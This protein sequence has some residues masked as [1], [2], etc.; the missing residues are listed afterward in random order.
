MNMI[1][2]MGGFLSA[3]F[4]LHN[5]LES[6]VSSG[7]NSIVYLRQNAVWKYLH[8][9]SEG[10]TLTIKPD[11]QE[12]GLLYTIDGSIIIKKECP[13]LAILRLNTLILIRVQLADGTFRILGTNEYPLQATLRPITPSKASGFTGYELSFSGKQLIEP[14]LLTV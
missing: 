9:K 12:P 13:S 6:F 10:V 11:K 3:D 4:I 8:A 14:P 2:N 7:S 5:E 1:D